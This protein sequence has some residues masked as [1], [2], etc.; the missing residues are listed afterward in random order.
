MIGS[1]QGGGGGGWA[2]G[3]EWF[4]A[5]QRAGGDSG[6]SRNQERLGVIAIRGGC[7]RTA[8]PYRQE[9]PL[10][11]AGACAGAAIQPHSGWPRRKRRRKGPGWVPAPR[12]PDG[13]AWPGDTAGGGGG[14]H[15]APAHGSGPARVLVRAHRAALRLRLLRQP[16]AVR[17]LLDPVPAGARQE[18][19]EERGRRGGRAGGGSAGAGRGRRDAREKVRAGGGAVAEERRSEKGARNAGAILSRDC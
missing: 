14:G 6:G 1:Q 7:L 4:S 8:W 11:I 18:P 10:A 15:H 2:L 19:D 16:P 17:A 9:A 13:C 12:A 5:A 3:R